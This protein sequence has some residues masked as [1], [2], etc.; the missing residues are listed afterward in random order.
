MVDTRSS[1]KRKETQKKFEKK[2]PPKKQKPDSDSDSD[3]VDED[4]EP[5]SDEEVSEPSDEDNKSS[6]SEKDVKEFE[7]FLESIVNKLVE[8]ICPEEDV[9]DANDS[10]SDSESPEK[11][12]M[13]KGFIIF[14]RDKSPQ[15][16]QTRSKYITNL[17]PEEKD[18]LDKMEKQIEEL[19][20]SKI[21]P[22]Y[23]VLLSN[24]S[25]SSKQ[26]ILSIMDRVSH[27]STHS[28]EYGKLNNWLDGVLSI[29]FD[30]YEKLPV[31]LESSNNE[32]S[33]FFCNVQQCLNNCIYGQTQA[34]QSILECVGKWIT[35]PTS[36]NK[37]ISFVGEKGT[38][39]TSL[40]KNGIAKALGRPFFLIS[41][42]GESDSS[43][44]KG[45]DY[46]YEGSKWGCIVDTLI[47]A[48][49]MNPIILFDE[50][51]KVSE[52]YKGDEIIGMLMHLT[53]TTQ[54]DKFMDKYFSGIDIDLSQCLF[55]FSYND[56]TKIN[57]IL[58][59][60]LTQ[61]EFKSFNKKEK[62]IIAKNFLIPQACKNI[63]LLT[64]T[65]AIDNNTIE[66]IINRY[67]PEEGGVRDLE[68][69]IYILFKRLNLIK[70]P[71]NLE[72]DYKGDIPVKDGKTY[73]DLKIIDRLL[74]DMEPS[75]PK[76]SMYC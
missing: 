69:I 73:I 28:S 44:Y 67:S 41:L 60:R 10:F 43:Y 57:P 20:S 74:K 52:T 30:T 24:I 34:K 27:K 72:L 45:H 42:G 62:F 54:N 64:N 35:N 46:T 4:T 23:K 68:K 13:K 76:L 36:S 37:P 14:S 38:G 70:L 31:S 33:D 59:D 51:D 65:I 48:K 71:Q 11:N 9:N 3:Y 32:I 16:P 53:D 75:Q 2:S 18:K 5:S 40:A 15:T 21:P 19:N 17:T 29:P 49:C 26:K 22:R 63:G 8:E 1:K 12:P 55:I 66:E 7:N 39:K 47:N 56:E 6:N 50:L 25:L 58:L 61:I